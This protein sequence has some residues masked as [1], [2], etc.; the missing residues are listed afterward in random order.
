MA[1]ELTEGVGVV[2]GDAEVPDLPLR[3]QPFEGGDELAAV[4][5]VWRRTV[6]LVD[7]DVV[8]TQPTQAALDRG[9]EVAR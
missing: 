7:V 6:Q 9:D 2:G 1:I 4:D 8:G 3:L 5:D